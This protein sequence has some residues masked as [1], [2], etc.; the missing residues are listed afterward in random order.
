MEGEERREQILNTMKQVKTPISGSALA[1]TFL[2]SRQV[3]VQDIALLRAVNKNI[4]ST[5][6]GYLLYEP[7]EGEQ[8]ARRIFCVRHTDDDI[9]DE[10]Y[11]IIDAG[12]KILDVIIDH[13]LYG[14]ITV[15]LLLRSRADVD[16]FTDKMKRSK[17]RPLKNLTKE[18]HYHTIEA[19]T[20]E[21]LENIEQMLR[22][23]GYLQEITTSG[24]RTK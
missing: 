15:D 13:A 21:V 16:E 18:Q 17:D 14:Q 3:I 11:T 12:G 20:E 5:N 7:S 9:R 19:D 2:V 4:L 10:L 8:I 22:E 6:K 23:K 1:K 24:C